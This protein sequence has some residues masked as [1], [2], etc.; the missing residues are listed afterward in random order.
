MAARSISRPGD[1][2]L[3]RDLDLLKVAEWLTWLTGTIE[4]LPGSPCLGLGRVLVWFLSRLA[5]LLIV[6]LHS[7]PGP[8]LSSPPSQPWLPT[9]DWCRIWPPG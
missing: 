5:R 8:S 9:L 7:T 6:L 2:D 1:L 3:L 4:Q